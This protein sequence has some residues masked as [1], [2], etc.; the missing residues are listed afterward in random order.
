MSDVVVI[1]TG[2]GVVGIL[3]SLFIAVGIHKVNRRIEKVNRMQHD[4]CVRI[5]QL[6]KPVKPVNTCKSKCSDGNWFIIGKCPVCGQGHVNNEDN[7]YCGG[8]ARRLDWSD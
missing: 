2:V 6:Q 1:L 7:K 4:F 8:C 5:P 3:L